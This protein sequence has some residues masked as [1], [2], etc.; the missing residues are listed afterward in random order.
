MFVADTSNHRI[1]VIQTPAMQLTASAAA[2]GAA[3]AAVSGAASGAVFIGNDPP[4]GKFII[5]AGATTEINTVTTNGFTGRYIRVRPSLNFGDGF[6]SIT[7]IIVNDAAGKNLALNKPVYAV[8]TYPGWGAPNIV[9]N[10]TTVAL[11]GAGNAWASHTNT[12]QEFIEVDLGASLPV[13]SIRIITLAGYNAAVGID[14]TSQTRIEINA[15][16]EA[17][18]KAAYAT[19]VLQASAAASGAFV[20]SGAVVIGNDPPKGKFIVPT[21][22]IWFLFDNR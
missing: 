19:Q 20:A 10:G 16:T 5:P 18:P 1:R 3:S 21:G 14:R 17:A 2:S 9:T 22:A 11:S 4:R 8:S 13:T 15:D 12:R 6:P 7:Q